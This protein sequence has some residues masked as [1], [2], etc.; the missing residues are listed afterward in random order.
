MAPPPLPLAAAPPLDAAALAL[1]ELTE[2]LP[3][4]VNDDAADER[5]VGASSG[6]EQPECARQ[7]ASVS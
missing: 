2:R 3:A 7:F 6:D 4:E 1:R 5:S